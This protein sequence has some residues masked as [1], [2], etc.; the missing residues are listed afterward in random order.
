MVMLLVLLVMYVVFVVMLYVWLM[1]DVNFVVV[2]DDVDCFVVIIVY[3]CLC[4]DYLWC[5][6]GFDG[7]DVVLVMFEYF[8]FV[9][10]VCN[11]VYLCWKKFFV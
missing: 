7:C 8:F 9:F 1:D 10:V 5:D 4:F 3:V 2:C 6:F 11:V